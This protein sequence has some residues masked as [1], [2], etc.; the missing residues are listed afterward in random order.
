MSNK[1]GRP[2]GTKSEKTKPRVNDLLKAHNKKQKDLAEFIPMDRTALNNVLAARKGLTDDNADRIA[3]FFDY[4]VSPA[5]IQG[6]TDDPTPEI[7]EVIHRDYEYNNLLNDIN[8]VINASMD[9][10][11]AY[12]ITFEFYCLVNEIDDIPDKHILKYPMLS[13][14]EPPNIKSLEH[15]YQSLTNPIDESKIHCVKRKGEIIAF[16]T[17]SDLRYLQDMVYD[18]MNVQFMSM[19]QHLSITYMKPPK[20]KTSSEQYSKFTKTYFEERP[21]QQKVT[22][23]LLDIAAREF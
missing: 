17:Q 16:I 13:A 19:L 20:H 1:V 11:E 21:D 15:M 9:L 7:R 2:A 22:E 4:E 3:A 5:Y 6:K 23:E 18:F 14:S 8:S 12:G 10:F